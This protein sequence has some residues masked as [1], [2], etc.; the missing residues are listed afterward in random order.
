ML[1]YST[2]CGTGPAYLVSVNVGQM[3]TCP[4][5]LLHL[6]SRPTYETGDGFEYR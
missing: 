6:F 1:M 2:L 5:I 4:S 3:D